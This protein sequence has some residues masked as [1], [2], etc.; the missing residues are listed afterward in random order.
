MF[1]VHSHYTTRS[2]N[3]RHDHP[4]CVRRRAGLRHSQ[5]CCARPFAH[6]LP[7]TENLHAA[8]SLMCAMHGSWARRPVRSTNAWSSS[9]AR[10]WTCGLPGRSIS[11]LA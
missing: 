2:P 10:T 1:P 9:R 6:G 11:I 7:S 5:V 3:S 4:S 8:G